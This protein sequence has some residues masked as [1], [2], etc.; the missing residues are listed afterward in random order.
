MSKYYAAQFKQVCTF[1]K[2]PPPYFHN[3]GKF[4][5]KS[6]RFGILW[7][8]DTIDI[9]KVLDLLLSAIENVCKL[10]TVKDDDSLDWVNFFKK[11]RFKINL[12]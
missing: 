9:S 7:R 6:K 2:L 4:W 8:N 5:Q 10:A 12:S 1:G 11:L 3:S